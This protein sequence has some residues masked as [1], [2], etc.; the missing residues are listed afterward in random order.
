MGRKYYHSYAISLKVINDKYN[1]NYNSSYGKRNNLY[2][3][4]ISRNFYYL[5]SKRSKWIKN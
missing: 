4:I 2:V 1:V 5:Y 3:S